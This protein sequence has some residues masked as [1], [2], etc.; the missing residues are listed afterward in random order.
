MVYK[1]TPE[2]I[3]RLKKRID[4]IQL[5]NDAEPAPIDIVERLLKKGILAKYSNS[6]VGSGDIQDWYSLLRNAQGNLQ[7]Y[8]N[9]G[10]MPKGNEFIIDSLFCEY[11]YILNLDSEMAEFYRGFQTYPH[12]HGRY[13][14]EIKPYYLENPHDTLYYGCALVDSFPMREIP[15]DWMKIYDEKD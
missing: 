12:Y 2:Q 3:E 13:G 1:K 6:M 5:I 9:I 8:I 14:R 7:A 11:A 4:K 10:Y 15:K